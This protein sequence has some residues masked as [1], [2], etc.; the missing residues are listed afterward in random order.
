[1]SLIPNILRTW[2]RPVGFT[3]PVIVGKF[4]PGFLVVSYRLF[5]FALL[6]ATALQGNAHAAT[7]RSI[8]EWVTCNGTTDDTSGTIEAFAAAAKSA[9]TLVVDCPVRLHSG[10]AIDR[11][12]FIDTGTT[13]KF[14]SAGKFVVDNLFHP[15]FVIVNSDNITLSDWNVVWENSVPINPNVGGYEYGGKFIEHA[16]SAQPAGMFNDIVLTK[17]LETNR[18]IVFNET[19]GYV[20]PVWVGAVNLS[21]V[22][23]IT[24]NTYNVIFSGLK[25]TVPTTA[26]GHSFMPMAFSLS[27]NWLSRQTV[28]GKTPRTAKYV[29]VPHGLT[30]S[31]ITLDGTL[32]GWQGNVQ[33]TMFENIVS[34]RYGDLQDANGR[35]VGGI[36]KWFPPPHLF[37]LNYA[38][39]GDPKLFNSNLHFDNVQDV[40]PR[41]GVARDKGGSDTISGYALSLKLGCVDC[42]VDTYTSTRPDGFMDL[43]PSENLTVSNVVA[44]F[45]SAFIHN[46]YPVGLRFPGTGSSGVT[47]IGY[48]Y[49]TFENVQM[50]DTAASTLSG[51]IGNASSA[52]NVGIVFKN[53]HIDLT[54]W[55]E[56]DLPLSTI[57]G[58]S[59]NVALTFSMSGQSMQVSH[60]LYHT[61]QTTLVETPMTVHAGTAAVKL[62]W[63]SRGADKCTAN[64]A[65][66]GAVALQGSK[67]VTAAAAAKYDFGLTCQ[68]SSLSSPTSLLVTTE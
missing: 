49:V 55:A 63:A 5:L 19:H 10:L 2:T 44:S 29:G 27:D 1:M 15:A 48:K 50:K 43:L 54:R 52:T 16:G 45:D 3:P 33:N 24:G 57:A 42:S 34:K 26:G 6:V 58:N 36:G 67:V 17:W 40:G 39:E 18:G 21:A 14:T 12:I 22:F 13:V 64:G 65:W 25:L 4:N 62:T 61:V 38:Y 59:N 7:S 35:N 28:T 8:K 31:G 37:Y 9:F 68:N 41:V 30:F 66:T 23:Y 20:N 56:S 51:I 53:F 46:V 60:L 11:A 47:G 32:M